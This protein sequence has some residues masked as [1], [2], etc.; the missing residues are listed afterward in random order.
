MNRLNLLKFDWTLLNLEVW[1]IVVLNDITTNYYVNLYHFG[2]IWIWIN[3]FIKRNNWKL[4]MNFEKQDFKFMQLNF[5]DIDF[6]S[7]I[8]CY[9]KWYQNKS[10]C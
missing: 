8:A 5:N 6:R 7:L 2:Q 4:K 1:L 3:Q 9:L 10:L